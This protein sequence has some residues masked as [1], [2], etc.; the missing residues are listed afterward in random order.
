MP[1]QKVLKYYKLMT[2]LWLFSSLPLVSI[3]SGQRT[4]YSIYIL[5]NNICIVLVLKKDNYWSQDKWPWFSIFGQKIINNTIQR[6]SAFRFP[7]D[8]GT[9][10]IVTLKTI[11][12]L[13]H[14]GTEYHKND[15]YIDHNFWK[16]T[17]IEYIQKKIYNQKTISSK[18]NKN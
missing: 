16:R 13:W 15:D 5:N 17:K 7:A 8:A 10:V 1:G 4:P 14:V 11:S 9:T 12:S 18:D 6:E 2:N 3:F